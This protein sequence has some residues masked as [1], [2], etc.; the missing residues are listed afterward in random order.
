MYIE[1]KGN[2][3][4]DKKRCIEIKRDMYIEKKEMY[5]EKKRNVFRDKD[6]SIQGD[7]LN[8]CIST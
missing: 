4:R 7:F 3:H 2:V 6:I 8:K 1:I 5:M